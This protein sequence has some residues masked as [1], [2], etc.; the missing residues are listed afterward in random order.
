MHTSV[1]ASADNADGQRKATAAGED[2]RARL[3]RMIVEN[4]E[5][6]KPKS[7]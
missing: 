5:A 1:K 4:E 6:R 2:V 7:P 3:L